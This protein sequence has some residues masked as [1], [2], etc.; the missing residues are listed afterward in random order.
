MAELED[1]Y[2]SEPYNPKGCGGA[3]PPARTIAQ[4]VLN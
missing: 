2:G 3:N 4:F 1:A